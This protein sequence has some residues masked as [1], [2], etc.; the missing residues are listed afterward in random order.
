VENILEYKTDFTVFPDDLNFSKTLFG[1]RLLEKIDIASATL[2]RKLLYKTEADGAVT[3]S[4]DKI[5]FLTPAHLGDL[6]TIKSILK[7]LG[8][9]SM[10]IRCD[11]TKENLHGE[12]EK[13]CTGIITFVAVKNEKPIPHNLCF[14][15]LI[16]NII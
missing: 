1:G 3:A 14:A 7:S 8:R 9:S 15:D 4:M 12:V 10:V 5:D 16:K 6:I 11:V 13:I 2:A